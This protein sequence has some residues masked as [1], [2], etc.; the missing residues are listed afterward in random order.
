MQCRMRYLLGLTSLVA[1]LAGALGCPPKPVTITLSP[2][3]PEVA[4]GATLVMSATSTDP[5]DKT[6]LWSAG[7]PHIVAVAVNGTLRGIALGQTTISAKG[8]HSGKSATRTVTVGVGA[9][10]NTNLPS[11]PGAVIPQMTPV[12]QS[13]ERA[14]C[15]VQFPGVAAR[16]W[17]QDNRLFHRLSLPD[18]GSTEDPGKPELPFYTL[19]FAVPIDTKTQSPA[20]SQV[21]V[22]IE[23]TIDI[24]NVMVYP[25]QPPAWLDETPGPDEGQKNQAPPQAHRPPFQFDNQ[26]YSSNTPYPEFNSRTASFRVGNLD[27]IEVRVFPLH[28]IAAQK[29]LR[30]ATQMR[31]KV[32]FSSLNGLTAPAVLGD[33]TEAQELMNEEWLVSATA[34]PAIIETLGP[35][36]LLAELPDFDPGIHDEG[37]QLLI[38]TRDALYDEAARLANWRRDG[39]TRVSLYALS[40]SGY[41]DWESIRDVIVYLDENNRLH[42][43]FGRRPHAMSAILLFGDAEII[44]TCKGMNYRG[45]ADPVGTQDPVSIVGT[46]LF[47]ATIRGTDEMPD[48]A[49]GR[50]SVDDATQ[51]AAVV[52]KIIRYESATGSPHRMAVYGYFDDVP[53]RYE[54]FVGQ[55]T[56]TVGSTTV[57]GIGSDYDS[58]FI[59]HAPNFTDYIR[60]RDGYDDWRDWSR[61]DGVTDD[62]H[63]ELVAPFAGPRDI[64]GEAELGYLDGEDDWEFVKTA[65]RVRQFMLGKGIDVAFGYAM[66]PRGP[67]PA[68]GFDGSP[69][70][71]DLLAYAFN[72]STS[73]IQNNWRQGLDAFILHSD[74]GYRGGWGHPPF[75]KSNLVFLVHPVTGFYPIVFSINC[76]SGWFD[77]ETDT[78]IWNDGVIRA[79]TDTRVTSESFCEAALRF[80]GG[81][82]VATFGAVRGSDAGRND[83]LVDGIWGSLYADFTAGSMGSG[84]H[85]TFTRLGAA[86]RWA[87]L[88]QR[89]VLDNPTYE[90]YNMQ[91]YH[92]FGDPMLR[93]N[94]PTPD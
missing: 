53:E 57:V 62:T 15:V 18:A 22:L 19:F 48:V 46:D 3:N 49:I 27:M 34:N 40:E 12:V 50:I 29:R 71:A 76:S 51:A 65:E 69:L 33:F 17:N 5:E 84:Y 11:E 32:E 89:A 55:S 9:G 25:A 1:I 41:P 10:F 75:D 43:K 73:D 35:T 64:T 67:H 83:K 77:N 59:R 42:M 78:R 86:M 6:F 2:S 14:E 21:S 68:R 28:Y 4:V 93:I 7:N 31:V 63:L 94:F 30:L 37:F 16:V 20:T 81:G 80:A 60:E 8:S 87:K 45:H 26:A 36:E 85:P 52:D 88:H 79:D 70:P 66:N 92:L 72:C 47:Y 58:Q 54:M 38:L 90:R 13:V 44:P 39:G 74:H 61:I 56:F 23:D 24:Q 91:I 82:A